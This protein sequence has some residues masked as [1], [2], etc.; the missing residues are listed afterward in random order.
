MHATLNAEAWAL[1]EQEKRRDRT[2]RRVSIAAW[3]ATIVIVGAFA[4]LIALRISY[5]LKL[6][7]VG[8]LEKGIV[9]Q[10]AMPLVVVLG[11]VS[12]LIATLATIGVFLR[13]RTASLAEIQLRLS[14][15]EAMLAGRDEVRN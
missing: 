14:A 5:M 13:L 2:L 7:A 3:V 1:V 11:V 15:L 8:M 10:A 6:T 4:V 9:L 12:L